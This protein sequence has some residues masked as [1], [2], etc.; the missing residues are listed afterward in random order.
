[1]PNSPPTSKS[2]AWRAILLRHET[3]LL[4]VLAFE[5]FHFNSVGPRFGT[6]DNT[7][8]IV[9]HSVEIGLLALV[10]TPI[11]SPAASIF[12]LDHCSVCARFCSAN[13]GVMPDCPFHSRWPARSESAL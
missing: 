6:L 11:I 4:L 1:M 2:A 13:C 5:W 8:D 12:Q 10:L 7:F 3:V 9:R